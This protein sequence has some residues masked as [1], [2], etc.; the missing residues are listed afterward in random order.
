M[1]V[2]CI[3]NRIYQYRYAKRGMKYTVDMIFAIGA[4]CLSIYII[5]S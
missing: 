3:L 4:I 5:V 1:I 2:A